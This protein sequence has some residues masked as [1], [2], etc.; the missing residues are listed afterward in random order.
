LPVAGHTCADVFGGFG[1]YSQPVNAMATTIALT[2]LRTI[3]KW[4][5]VIF[6][7]KNGPGSF[8]LR[9]IGDIESTGR[10]H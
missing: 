7:R 10:P 8:L 3:E 4:T 9:T 1:E 6:P 5:R 2:T